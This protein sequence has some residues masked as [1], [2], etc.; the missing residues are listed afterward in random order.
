MTTNT[1]N[2]KTCN[3]MRKTGSFVFF[4]VRYNCTYNPSEENEK[5]HKVY[6][7]REKPLSTVACFKPDA[8]ITRIREAQLQQFVKIS[9]IEFA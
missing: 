7:S 4:G 8:S 5:G 6:Y 2:R 3:R 9:D 1:C